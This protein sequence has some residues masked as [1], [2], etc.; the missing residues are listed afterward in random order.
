MVSPEE[1]AKYVGENVG[2][3]QSGMS[4]LEISTLSTS[5]KTCAPLGISTK[6]GVAGVIHAFP[7]YIITSCLPASPTKAVPPG[8]LS[9][10]LVP[11][12]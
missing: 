12:A 10:P 11:S 1:D 6:V 7:E 8:C 3:S 2:K 4:K 5:G 9:F